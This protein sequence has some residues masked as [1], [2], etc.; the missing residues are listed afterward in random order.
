MTDA[1]RTSS[2]ITRAFGGAYSRVLICGLISTAL[3]GYWLFFGAGYRAMQPTAYE[4][5]TSLLLSHPST[6]SDAAQAIESEG[7][8]SIVE[9]HR[10]L[11]RIG[12]K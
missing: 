2:I 8:L 12:N 7:F 3:F 1:M 10:L 11:D 5:T 9:Q 6:S 4:L